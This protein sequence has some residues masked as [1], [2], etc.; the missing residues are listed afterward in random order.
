MARPEKNTVDYFPHYVNSGKTLFTVEQRF[1][2][3]GYAF[4]FKILEILGKTENH[5]IDCRK[6]ADYEYLL[7]ITKVSREKAEEIMELLTTLGTFDTD[8]WGQRIIFSENFVKDGISTQS[9]EGFWS[10][11]KRGIIGIYHHV[12]PQHLDKYLAEFEFRYNHRSQSD[13][14]QL[15]LANC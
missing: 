3:D 1:G 6:P 5:F 8:M 4:L 13:L 10:L 14:F 7:A 9:I 15:I 11:L 2:N 12:S